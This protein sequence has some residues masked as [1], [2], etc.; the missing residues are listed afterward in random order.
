MGYRILGPILRSP[1]V[2]KFTTWAV[3]I[4]SQGTMIHALRVPETHLLRWAT[5]PLSCFYRGYSFFFTTPW[6]FTSSI[7][8]G[9]LVALR[10]AYPLPF[11]TGLGFRV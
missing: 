8:S 9:V 11:S 7:C 4:V 5:N 6:T 1:Y 3:V 2:G 10:S